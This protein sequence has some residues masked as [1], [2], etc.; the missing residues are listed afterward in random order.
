[1]SD[2]L[3]GSDDAEPS[4]EYVMY[5][6][7]EQPPTEEAESEDVETDVDE[8]DAEE[9]EAQSQSDEADEEEDADEEAEVY[10]EPNDFAKYEFDEESGLYEFK[11]MGKKVRVNVPQ[12][13]KSWQ[14]SRKVE[15][16]IERLAT[17]RKGIFDEAKSK[18][19][20]A[21]QEQAKQYQASVQKLAD[22]VKDSEMSEEQWEELRDTDIHEYT[23]LKELKQKR[24]EALAQ[25]KQ[26]SEA[27]QLKRRQ[28]L[29]SEES[30]KL[31]QVVGKEWADPEVREKEFSEMQEAML[32]YGITQE[33]MKNLL[34]HRVWVVVRDAMRYQ[35]AQ[36][37]VSSL[38]EDKKPPKKVKSGKAAPKDADPSIEE[39]FYGSN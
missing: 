21:L 9:S 38:K 26:E 28:E 8:S 2:N 5:G 7:S 15:A 22:L 18:E 35:K 4:A 13:I 17:E 34:D 20:T 6:E 33:E 37:K 12:L 31:L 16:E 27:Q 32:G 10:D 24:I 39:L 19:L 30:A 1:M 29:I 14:G 23:R 36:Q 3:L 25:A 11:S